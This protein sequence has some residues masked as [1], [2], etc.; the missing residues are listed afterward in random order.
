MYTWHSSG[1]H[2]T[3]VR[4]QVLK[5]Q[6]NADTFFF[7][8]PADPYKTRKTI[9]HA[10]SWRL[11]R[12]HPSRA[13]PMTSTAATLQADAQRRVGDSAAGEVAPSSW[14]PAPSVR[15]QHRWGLSN[16]PDSF[17]ERVIFGPIP[18]PAP[19]AAQALPRHIP[20]SP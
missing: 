10:S 9:S 11:S 15:L 1:W 6:G 16:I 4:K 18:A 7:H 13:S 8:H 20:A 3:P 17:P 14:D 19:S 2:Y 5:A 12:T